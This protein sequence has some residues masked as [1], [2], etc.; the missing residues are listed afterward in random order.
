MRRPQACRA[1]AASSHHLQHDGSAGSFE[2]Q[3]YS[4]C[5]LKLKDF[6]FIYINLPQWSRAEEQSLILDGR[7]T[8]C[9]AN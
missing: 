2:L 4:T 5:T 3:I 8:N 1:A 9:R 7:L 6:R